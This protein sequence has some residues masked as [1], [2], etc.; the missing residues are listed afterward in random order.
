MKEFET[1]FDETMY[2]CLDIRMVEINSFEFSIICFDS[3][4]DAQK[5]RSFPNDAKD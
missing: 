3:N 5:I 1:D 4:G 2:I